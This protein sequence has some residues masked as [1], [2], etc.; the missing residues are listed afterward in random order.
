MLWLYLCLVVTRTTAQPTNITIDAPE[1]T[2]NHG[3]PN[4]LCTPTQWTDYVMFYVGNYVAHVA[5]V[6]TFPGESIIS[7]CIGMIAALFFPTSGIVRGLAAII[8]LSIIEPDPL[9]A[10]ARAGALCMVVRSNTWTPKVGD[11]V[12][13]ILLSHRADEGMLGKLFRIFVQIN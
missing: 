13:G 12:S 6:K 8:R 5:T 9:Q 10:A 11:R 4:I 3:D 7:C 2:T 1:G